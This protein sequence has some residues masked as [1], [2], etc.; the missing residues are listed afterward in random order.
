VNLYAGGGGTA[1]YV[2]SF[3]GGA[4]LTGAQTFWDSLDNMLKYDVILLA[5]DGSF[6]QF[7]EPTGEPMFS[8]SMTARQSLESFANMGGR[9]FASH[10]QVYWFER[11]S[12]AFQSIAMFNRG[13]A[14][15][16]SFT[17]TIDQSFAGGL[18]LAQWMDG[19]G[20]ST[21][22]GTVPIAQNAATTTMA[23]AT[24][25]ITSQQ[26][27]S[28]D[29]GARHTVQYLSATTPIPGGT[30]GRVVLSDLHVSSGAGTLSDMPNMD[31]PSGCL[32]TD[33]SPQEKVL[34]FMLFDIGTCVPLTGP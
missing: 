26:W 19:V 21:T 14:L 2:A 34:E 29:V 24:G 25:G 15:P 1:R 9:V 10:Y 23:A 30:C 31:F 20:G 6:G 12:P 3:N 18:A 32:T 4:T 13:P 28:S 5:C 8:K 22:L 33:L 11:G 17:A 27:I 7:A 16:N